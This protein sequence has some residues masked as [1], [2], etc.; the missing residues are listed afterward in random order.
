[1]KLS[2]PY[3][4]VKRFSKINMLMMDLL[5]STYGE[6]SGNYTKCPGT[7]KECPGTYFSC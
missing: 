2:K 5:S 6:C 4:K 7:Y 1:M 3:K